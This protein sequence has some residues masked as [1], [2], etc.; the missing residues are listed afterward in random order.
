MKH[1]FFV[2]FLAAIILVIIVTSG[3]AAPR[4][5]LSKAAIIPKL[6]PETVNSASFIDVTRADGTYVKS[7]L[8]RSGRYDKRIADLNTSRMKSIMSS[9]GIGA[10]CRFHFPAGSYYFNG[11]AAGWQASIQSTARN[12]SFTGDGVNATQIIQKSADVPATIRIT[13]SNCTI[14]DLSITSADTQATYRLD[15]DQH[16]LKTAIHLEFPELPPPAWGT[17]PQILNVNINTTGNN[18]VTDGFCRPFET[19]IKVNGPWLN[20]TA[21][22]MFIHDVHNAIYINQGHMLAGPATFTDIN[23]VATAIQG[24]KVPQ[25]WNVFFK[26]ESNFM[27]AVSLINCFY[28]GSQFISMD[29]SKIAL[30]DRNSSRIPTTPAYLMTVSGCYVNALWQASPSDD[31]KWSSIYMNLPPRPGGVQ[32]GLGEPL[33]SH[34]LIFKDN[35]F[36]GKTPGHGA[37]FYTEGNVKNLELRGNEFSSGGGDRAIY[38]RTNKPLADSDVAVRNITIADNTFMDFRNPITVGGSQFDPSRAV[39]AASVDDDP[40]WAEG[41]TIIGN[42]SAYFPVTERGQLT[43]IFVNRARRVIVSGNRLAKTVG[44]PVIL[45][46]CEEITVNGNIIAG[47][48][49]TGQNAIYLQRCKNASINGNTLRGFRRG[50]WLDGSEGIAL[51]GNSLASCQ[52][53]LSLLKSPGLSVMGNVISDTPEGILVGSQEAAG[54]ANNTLLRSGAIRVVDDGGGTKAD[55]KPEPK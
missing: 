43:S 47:I 26:S 50:I 23:A 2:V 1:C 52:T 9:S 45:R 19:G 4:E 36:T 11:A 55:T 44:S 40:F 53:G 27:E 25:P 34:T 20:I 16:P 33:Y 8:I 48:N 29:G 17:D 5:G 13:H 30:V 14:Q 51:T 46:E 6:M 31:A 37:F 24:P 39:D 3:N 35:N 18:M 49:D 32:P 21:H 7:P 22:T 41:V 12:Q 10:H 54:V 42:Q 15:W 28:M 38:V